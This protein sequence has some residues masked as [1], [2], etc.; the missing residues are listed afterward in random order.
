MQSIRIIEIPKMKAVYSGPLSTKEKFEKF[1]TWFS[2][3]HASLPCELFPRDF[4]WY[5]ERSNASEWFY[6]LP[7]NADLS[8]ITDY[9]IVDLPFG[10]FA[11][12]SCLDA[13]LDEAKDWMSTREAI[14]NWVNESTQFELYINGADKVER[15]PMFHIVSPGWLMS[16]GIAFENLYIP[17]VLAKEET[18]DVIH[19]EVT[20]KVKSGKR[21]E[22]YRKVMEAG[23]PEASKNEEGN[24]K[25]EYSLP[26]DSEDE[27]FLTEIWT[28]EE[29]QSAHGKTPHYQKLSEIKKEYVIDTQIKRVND[30]RQ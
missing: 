8:E 20:Y 25:Y 10:L 2:K 24:L 5:N 22:F 26:T 18:K 15:Y 12:A 1:N 16:K 11:V 6:A 7:Q 13:D 9:E 17:I 14:M 30:E 4:M 21:E 3:Y 29:T 19:V 27:V 28:S 23:I